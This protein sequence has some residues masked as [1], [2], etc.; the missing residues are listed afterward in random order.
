LLDLIDAMPA[1]VS[2]R[3]KA[4]LL[5]A[6][7]PEGP[8]DPYRQAA[9]SAGISEYVT[10]HTGFIPSPQVPFFFSA[11]DVVCLPYRQASQSGVL[12]TAYQFARPVVVTRVGGL[13]ESVEEGRNGFVVTP[14]DPAL[15]ADALARLLADPGQKE[16]F[17][18]RS[19]ELAQGSLSWTH[20]A[21]MT[22]ALYSETVALPR[23]A[24]AK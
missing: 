13:P 21:D 16:R 2:R 9:A 24:A 20:V 10:F 1:L 6:G 11:S 23:A 22:V 14:A 7:R 8:I 18:H 15:L 5:I 12:L 3:P 17:G 4:H 19:F